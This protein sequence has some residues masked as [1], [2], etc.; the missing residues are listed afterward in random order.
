MLEEL[1]SLE[2]PAEIREA[3]L[4]SLKQDAVQFAL[5]REKKHGE[6]TYVDRFLTVHIGVSISFLQIILCSEIT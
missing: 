6:Y 1:E 4:E 2:V 5:M 3:R